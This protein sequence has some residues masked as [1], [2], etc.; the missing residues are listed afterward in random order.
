MTINPIPNLDPEQEELIR[1]AIRMAEQAWW[2][3]NAGAL[4]HQYLMDTI[5]NLHAL[6]GE[7]CTST[8]AGKPAKHSGAT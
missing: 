8:P 5:I 2:N 3:C 4:A 7:T 6:L 1:D